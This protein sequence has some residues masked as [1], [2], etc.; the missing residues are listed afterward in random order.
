MVWRWR[1]SPQ[2]RYFCLCFSL[3]CL[4]LFSSTRC[5]RSKSGTGKCSCTFSALFMTSLLAFIAQPCE[6]LRSP[7]MS[8]QAECAQNLISTA[9]SSGSGMFFIALTFSQFGFNPS[10]RTCPTQLI[11]VILILHF[12]LVNLKL[13]LLILSSSSLSLLLCCSMSSQ[14]KCHPQCL[15]LPECHNTIS[16]TSLL[17]FMQCIL[18]TLLELTIPM[19]G[20]PSPSNWVNIA[21]LT[22]PLGSYWTNPMLGLPHTARWVTISPSY[23]NSYA[24]SQ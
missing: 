8:A 10:V 19:R 15:Q 22:H 14:Q 7:A 18:E 17:V 2:A 16:T 4:A 24:G 20:E 12:S 3:S 1:S 13:M 11:S 6:R 5:C 21:I 23:L 9:L